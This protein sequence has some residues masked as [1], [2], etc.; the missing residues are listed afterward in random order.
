M[1]ARAPLSHRQRHAAVARLIST[2]SRSIAAQ[3][4]LSRRSGHA[5][6][7]SAVVDD[8]LLDVR[9]GR[10]GI[11]PGAGIGVPGSGNGTRTMR[12]CA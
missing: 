4:D 2:Y 11:A 10:H 12:A 9:R 1:R 7:D 3:A 5:S 8:F 6:S